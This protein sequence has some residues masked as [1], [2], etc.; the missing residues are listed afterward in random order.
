LQ[1]GVVDAYTHVLEQ[2]LTYPHEG[3]TRSHCRRI[4]Q[5]LIQVG[6][7]VV[8]NPKDYALA[9]NFMW[10]CTMALNGLIQGVPSD[11]AT[12]MIGHELT[13]LYGID[14]A[15]T[16]AVVGPNLYR[17]MFETKKGKLAQYGKR[18]FNLTGTEDEIANRSH[19]QNRCVFPYHGNGH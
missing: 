14:H 17:V 11:W 18:I 6:P 15:R 9:S 12:H 2:Y 19:Q 13:A 1:N 10:S 8:E 3:F 16:L 4:L 5:T 7:E